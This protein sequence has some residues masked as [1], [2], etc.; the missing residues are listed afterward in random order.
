MKTYLVNF[1]DDKFKK[2]QKKLNESAL[3]FGVDKVFSFSP[4]DIV[5]TDFYEKNRIILEKKRGFGYWL[6]KP[7][8]IIDTLSKLNDGDILIY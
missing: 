7:Y 8:I 6:W 4:D 2:S 5:K 1:A 3:K